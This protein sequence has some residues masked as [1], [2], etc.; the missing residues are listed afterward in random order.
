MAKSNG[1]TSEALTV[2]I[3]DSLLSRLERHCQKTEL[4]QSQVVSLAH[5]RFLAAEMALDP[6]FWDAV[7]DKYEADSQL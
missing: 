3:K 5:K 7:Y 2:N 6:A 1:S 4:N